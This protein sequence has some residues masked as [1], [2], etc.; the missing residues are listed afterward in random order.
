MLEFQLSLSLSAENEIRIITSR[1]KSVIY[2]LWGD[3]PLL[4]K[5]KDIKIAGNNHLYLAQQPGSH[6]NGEKLV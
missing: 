2:E 4:I 3:C 6:Q 5:V 1:Y